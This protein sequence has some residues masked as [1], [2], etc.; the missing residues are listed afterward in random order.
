[1]TVARPRRRR[2]VPV[3]RAA[4]PPP[5]RATAS[6][7]SRSSARC[8]AGAAA[9]PAAAHPGRAPAGPAAGRPAARPG[10]CSR[11]TATAACARCW[12]I[13][14][15][16]S[17]QDPRERPAD[18]QA[19]GRR[20]AR[21][22]RATPTSD[23]LAYLNLWD[24]LR[25]Q[26]Q[27]LVRQPVPPAVPREF[28]NYLRV[29]EWQ[30]LHASCARSPGQLGLAPATTAPAATRT[31]VHTVAARRAAVAHRACTTARSAIPRRPR[32]AGSR[33]ARGRRW[34]RSRRAG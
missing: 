21:P 27:E 1:M 9:T 13:A 14:A 4:R 23:F 7:C 20:A 8:D 15:A 11:P 29:R 22:L 18:K 17:I 5:G 3:P 6:R 31:C 33:S 12:S 30:D 28:L 16:L 32:R 34:P 24:Y 26:Q 10:W 19:A 25:E 2:R